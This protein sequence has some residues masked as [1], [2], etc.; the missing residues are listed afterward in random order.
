MASEA[1]RHLPDSLKQA[2]GADFPWRNVADLGNVL[3]HTYHRSDAKALWDVYTN[4]L[5]ALELAIDAMILDLS[6]HEGSQT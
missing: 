6:S 4:D 2:H 1:S 5:D 3:R